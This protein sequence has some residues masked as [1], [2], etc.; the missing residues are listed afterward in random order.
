MRAHCL[1][2]SKHYQP[3][4]YF[5]G[6]NM[7]TYKIKVA[8]TTY[9]ETEVEVED[10]DQAWQAALSMDGGDFREIPNSGDWYV[11]DCFEIGEVTA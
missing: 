9:L 5:K 2:T 7:K 4:Q 3:F 1:R 10:E 6:Y 8:M 11:T